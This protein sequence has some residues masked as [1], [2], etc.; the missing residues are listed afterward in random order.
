[1]LNW[2]LKVTLLVMD[3]FWFPIIGNRRFTKLQFL[4]EEITI[5]SIL[6]LS[7]QLLRS[8]SMSQVAV[9][10]L[11]FISACSTIHGSKR[12]IGNRDS[13]GAKLRSRCISPLIVVAQLVWSFFLVHSGC[14]GKTLFRLLDLWVWVIEFQ[15]CSL[16]CKTNSQSG[17]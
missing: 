6:S 12:C 7:F 5:V 17:Q 14:F 4:G 9:L 8:R 13:D 1:M 2:T 15:L 11:R 3:W 10:R 16:H